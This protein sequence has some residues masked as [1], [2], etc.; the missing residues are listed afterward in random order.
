MT[1]KRMLELF[2]QEQQKARAKNRLA[3][4]VDN[5]LVTSLITDVL[6]EWSKRTPV[7]SRKP[8]MSM[9]ELFSGRLSWLSSSLENLAEGTIYAK[10]STAPRNIL[11]LSAVCT[12][13]RAQL[14][15]Y[16]TFFNLFVQPDS[17]D[18]RALRVAI[19]RL[20]SLT[21]R[22]ENGTV[23]SPEL[24]A[25]RQYNK[26]QIDEV[27]IEL[28]QNP[29]FVLYHKDKRSSIL[30]GRYSKQKSWDVLIEESKL[31]N[32]IAKTAYALY[33]NHA[34]SEYISII[35]FR[36]GFR[37]PEGLEDLVA[38]CVKQSVLTLS[39]FL[40]ELAVVLG[41]HDFYNGLDEEIKFKLRLWAGIVTGSHE[42]TSNFDL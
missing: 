31:Q 22:A 25:R 26:E 11:D 5:S 16:L 8:W 10:Y 13:A 12:I 27:H 24:D 32:E 38:N 34:H 17:E 36:E 40:R 30:K 39:I 1:E 6:L 3:Y 9:L 15:A 19:Y 2:A 14:E 28:K 21:V 7:S 42:S 37:D 29:V 18:E 33:A 41:V 4:V 35:Q 23:S 20:Q